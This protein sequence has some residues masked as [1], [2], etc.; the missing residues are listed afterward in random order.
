MIELL[1]SMIITL[2][3]FSLA[4]P[5]LKTQA[6]TVTDFGGRLDA[7]QNAR[8]AFNAID[9][10]LR[11]AGVGIL[12]DQPMLVY[13][14]SLGVTFNADIVSNDSLDV[15]AVYYNPTITDELAKSLPKTTQVQLF[16]SSML[17]PDSNYITLQNSAVSDAETISYWV[18][19]DSSA[20]RSDVFAL[21]RRV[22][23][24][25]PSLVAKNLIIEPGR[26]VFEY[27]RLT[28][29]TLVPVAGGDLPLV[30]VAV[31]GAPD[32]TLRSAWTDSIRVVRV[33]FSAIYVDPK[34]GEQKRSVDGSIRL[35]NA[36]LVSNPI[37]GVKPTASA[38][39]M[40]MAG[41]VNAPQIKLSWPPSSDQEGGEKDVRSYVLSRRRLPS[42]PFTDVV[43][44]PANKTT[45][46]TF[47]DQ[48]AQVKPGESYEYSLVALDCT[49]MR[50]DAKTVLT[51]LLP[52]P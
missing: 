25:A 20:A 36:G 47:T 23:N 19:H 1:I 17:Y 15:A 4:V 6:R 34:A 31:H 51:G 35:L 26:P 18:S 32:D 44:Q 43:S 24:A 38:L 21:W 40:T 5:F 13:A 27:M 45:T 10:E 14:D 16:P 52:T 7:Q 9:R 46:Y 41:S 33:R 2:V 3:I 28:G 37:C 12:N 39:S 50:S 22:N 42:G 11:M 49:P 48:G 30:H 8:F 29:G